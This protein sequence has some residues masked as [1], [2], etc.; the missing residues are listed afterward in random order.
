[1]TQATS[2]DPTNLVEKDAGPTATVTETLACAAPAAPRIAVASILGAGAIGAGIGLLATAAWLISRASQHPHES[3]LALAIVAVQFFGLS[4]GLFRYAQRLVVHDAAFRAL[5]DLRSGLYTRLETLAPAGLPAFRSGD[6]LARVVHD[7]DSVQDLIVRII[8]PFLIAILVGSATVFVVW[9]ILPAAGVILLAAVVLAATALPWV[10]AKLARRSESRQA[11]TRGEMTTAVVDLLHGAPELIA[12]GA[13]DEQLRKTAGIDARLQ[14]IAH[15]TAR[16]AGVGQG[17][18]TL[19][20][21]LATVGALLVGVAAV[22]AGRLDGLLLAVIAVVPLAAFELVVGLPAAAQTLQRVRRSLGRTLEITRMPPPVAEPSEPLPLPFPPHS[23]R[24]RGL[25]CRH[26]DDMPWALDGID[27]DL[28][29]GRR[30]AVVGRSGAG[31]TTLADVLLR[32]L[33]YQQGSVSIDGIEINELDGDDCRCVI[34]LVA[35]DAHVFN[36]TIEQNVRLAR[37]QA[38]DVELR[39]ALGRARLLDWSEKLPAGLRTQVGERGSRMSGGE[40]QRL[41]L[42]RALLADFPVLVLD[43][44]GEHLDPSTADAIVADALDATPGQGI[45]L[46]TH[47]LAGLEAVDEVIVLDRGRVI[48]RGMHGGLVAQGAVYAEMWQ[49]EANY[50]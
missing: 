41:A 26:R 11:T 32:F 7:A 45:L 38:T 24:V 44:P 27:L 42:A 33:P 9:W 31:K 21:G 19:L 13:M 28:S 35:Q 36:A 1:M 16:T 39:S 12:Y 46:I 34:G 40:R 22:R 2:Q 47:R 30:V 6:L 5:A 49:R 18:A 23:V 29:P 3:A 25:R 4:R 14:G 10:T 15:A 8:P 43:E 17:F 48:E 20:P 37:P 50:P